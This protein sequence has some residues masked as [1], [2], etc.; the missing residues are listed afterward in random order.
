MCSCSRIRAASVS[1]VSSSQT[2]TAFCR[3]IGPPSTEASM[4]W[5]VH[6]VTFTPAARASPGMGAGER[7]EQ[8]GMDVHDAHRELSQ[9]IGCHEAHETGED[10]ELRLLLSEGFHDLSLEGLSVLPEG[11]MVDD[12]GRD[13][14]LLRALDH[15]RTGDVADEHNEVRGKIAPIPRVG[16]ALE[17]CAASRGQNPD[18]E[19]AHRIPQCLKSRV[20]V[21]TIAMPCASA[22]SM[23]SASRMDPPGCATTATPPFANSS[24]PSRNGK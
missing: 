19:A 15:R 9:E 3:M 7:R 1:S 2:G 23:T 20:P 21:K 4:K 13:P 12:R 17:I 14:R 16:E 24:I 18:A 6:P 5:I 10:H 11:P 8:G 22:A